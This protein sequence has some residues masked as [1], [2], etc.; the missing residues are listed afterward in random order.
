MLHSTTAKHLYKKK[1]DYVIPVFGLA[2]AFAI[3]YL[4]VI[5]LFYE[6]SWNS[7]NEKVDQLVMLLQK[8]TTSKGTNDYWQTPPAYADFLKDQYPEVQNSCLMIEAWNGF[9]GTSKEEMV[10]DKS[11]FYADAS[12][13]SLFTF[14]FIYGS[15]STALNNP[16]NI[17][18]SESLAKKLFP[19][20]NPVGENVFFN[21]NIV[22]Q[23]SGV[24]QDI[25]TNS[26]LIPSY[27]CT[28]DLYNG[29]I[30]KGY[31]NN[32]TA[33]MFRTYLLL[34]KNADIE[35]LNG[36]ISN[37]RAERNI[38]DANKKL[39]FE[40]LNKIHDY[41]SKLQTYLSVA[42]LIIILAV[43]NFINIQCNNYIKR[44]KEFVIKRINGALPLSINRQ[45]F[46]ETAILITIAFM[47]AIFLMWLITPQYLNWLDIRTH[48]PNQFFIKYLIGGFFL[49]LIISSIT[50]F[51]ANSK[52]LTG[53]T[54]TYLTSVVGQ[55]RT[56]HT[57]QS[58]LVGF[59]LLTTII[60]LIA[61]IV[62]Y[63]QSDYI[64]N[65][66]LGVSPDNL[67]TLNF[68]PNERVRNATLKNT[69][70]AIPGV[71]YMSYS[72]TIPMY[73]NSTIEISN[74]EE[75]IHLAVSMNSIDD[76]FFKTFGINI[77]EG[78]DFS[79]QYNES[80]KCII[81]ETSAKQLQLDEPVNKW[82]K[83][84]SGQKV[85][86]IG[87]VNDFHHYSMDMHIPPMLFYAESPNIRRRGVSLTFKIDENN[88]KET[89]SQLNIA[90]NQFFPNSAFE[91][92]SYKDIV[93][94]RQEYETIS[95]REWIINS[96]TLLSIIISILG[97]FSIIKLQTKFKIKEIG[98]RKVN[99][100][101][102]TEILTMLNQDF[103]KSVLV[104]LCIAIPIA[105]YAMHK[106]LEGFAYKTELSWWMF[107]LA[108]VLAMGIALLT[109]SWQSWKAATR[110][111]VE[112]LR[113]E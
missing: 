96:F 51:I 50:I 77:L 54:K 43:F 100:A 103:I 83:T 70:T 64:I 37:L 30:W 58:I 36:K 108:G 7:H 106:W 112:A 81:N 60:F 52:S 24:Y 93:A 14:N 34:D 35:T 101:T 6:S 19:D 40:P 102:V 32:W 49:I 5:V 68:S 73:G 89:L 3:T 107:A 59:Q 91:L 42:L 66:N 47:I 31:R 18:L 1:K 61:S 94:A 10:N 15:P 105:W 28:L 71:E 79:T 84:S 57:G 45:L 72:N 11:G 26:S 53:T 62:I 41:K 38:E 48:I 23:V 76:D 99:G 86:I 90:L 74:N 111:P 20:K 87:V 82:I 22:L 2:V 17:A 13:F 92:K 33:D 67:Y 88:K 4:I 109:V 63:K 75:T 97:L 85:Q 80:N 69:L 16:R 46:T 29:T 25:P 78:R 12:I 98:I 27:L 110:N 39:Y 9:L 55:K 44:S 8:E 56:K 65:K 21:K 104:A 113:Y 95:R